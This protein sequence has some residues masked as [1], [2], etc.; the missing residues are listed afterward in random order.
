MATNGTRRSNGEGFIRQY[1]EGWRGSVWLD[2]R[3]RYF[4]GRIRQAVAD[5]IRRAQSEQQPAN[6]T[7]KLGEW[8]DQ[9]MAS[10][11]ANVAPSSRTKWRRWRMWFWS[12]V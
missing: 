5:K 12:G 8:M 4:R 3:R 7:M 9:W 6:G 10:H 11:H 2:G 1:P